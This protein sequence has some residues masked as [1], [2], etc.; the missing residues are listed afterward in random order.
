MRSI[1]VIGA[2]ANGRV[3]GLSGR[4]PWHAPADLRRFRQLTLG[5]AVVMGYR[6]WKSLDGPL[7]GRRN[8]VLA[9]ERTASAAG[10]VLAGSLDEA[11]AAVD[12]ETDVCLIGGTEVWSAG[13]DIADS[14]R[15]THIDADYPGDTFFPAIDLRVWHETDR[16]ETLS[17][18]DGV[19]RK[20]S[21]IDY[22]R[23]DR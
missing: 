2:V 13:L 18:V 1:I 14:L 22:V 21:F 8:I 23:G 12:D 15:L 16:I 3:A 5:K 9:R 7:G 4:M 19:D 6:T 11:L 10:A 17:A 20:I